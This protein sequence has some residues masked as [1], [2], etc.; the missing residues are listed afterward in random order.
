MYL[1]LGT[2]RLEKVTLGGRE[3][4]IRLLDH[5]VENQRPIYI[6]IYE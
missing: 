6:L 1:K 5:A 2:I 3:Y 4:L